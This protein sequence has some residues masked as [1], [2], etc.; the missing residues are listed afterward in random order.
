MKKPNHVR[1][2][3]QHQAAV[4]SIPGAAADRQAEVIGTEEA[5][6]TRGTWRCGTPR[7]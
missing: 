5:R 7:S 2:E 3:G 1:A 4:E 6:L